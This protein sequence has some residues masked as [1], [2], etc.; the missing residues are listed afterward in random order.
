MRYEIYI[1]NPHT[2][3]PGVANAH[4]KLSALAMACFRN[5]VL[6]WSSNHAKGHHTHRVYMVPSRTIGRFHMLATELV[7]RLWALGVRKVIYVIDGRAIAS[8]PEGSTWL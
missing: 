5:D 8:S 3:D 4:A 6:Q 2:T 1:P 7:A